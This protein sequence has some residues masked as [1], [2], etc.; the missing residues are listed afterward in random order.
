MCVT[1]HQVADYIPQLSR[2]SPDY[3]GVGVCTID[4]QRHGIGDVSTPFCL[5]SCSKPLTYAVAM[6]ELGHGVVHQYVGQEPS[7]ESFNEIKLDNKSE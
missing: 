2:F 3:W 6:H 1:T 4:G 7:G 5:Q